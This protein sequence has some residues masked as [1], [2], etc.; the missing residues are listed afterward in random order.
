MFR[1]FETLLLPYTTL[2]TPAIVENSKN[3]SR[4]ATVDSYLLS[5]YTT[6]KN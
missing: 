2:T 4:F 3:D 1:N 6:M 5:F